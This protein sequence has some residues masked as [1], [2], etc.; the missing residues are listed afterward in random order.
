LLAFF[1]SFFQ[2]FDYKFGVD[3]KTAARFGEKQRSGNSFPEVTQWPMGE[4]RLKN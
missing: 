4:R 3:T 2:L 1:G